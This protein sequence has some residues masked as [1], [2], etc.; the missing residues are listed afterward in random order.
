MIRICIE[1]IL[2]ITSL[3]H[4]EKI[5][6]RFDQDFSSKI[7]AGTL[8]V[9]I[10]D[11]SALVRQIMTDVLSQAGGINIRVAADPLI[12]MD[13]MKQS[14]PDVIVLDLVM[15]RMDGLTFLRKLMAENPIPVVVCSELVG[16]G[17]NEAIKALEMGAV[18]VIA[19]PKIGVSKFI[20]ES[21]MVLVDTVR[22]AASSRLKARSSFLNGSQ[23]K[24]AASVAP[25]KPPT[26]S[27]GFS[28]DKIIAL[29]ASTGGTDALKLILEAL[30]ADAPGIVIV[31]HM[32]EMFTAA[33][34]QRLNQSCAIE[35]KE[36]AN[37]DRVTAGRAL[38]A[39]G[40]YHMMLRRSGSSYTVEVTGGA[41]VSRHRPSVDVLF[42]SVAQ[43][44]G[45]KAIGAILTGMGS[46]GSMGLL[47]MKKAGAV[48]A[49]Q[50]EASCVVFGMPKEAISRG[51]ADHVISLGMMPG[52][53]M[54]K[55]R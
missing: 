1:Q 54:K 27:S 28:S 17:T 39:P 18:E 41:L 44:A 47:E 24:P 29:G 52:F 13:M 50:D 25:P 21:A 15:P 42:R 4:K 38:I 55:A 49:A 40:N 8:N 51:A 35:V 37:G 11:D 7:S 22:A 53:L 2:F 20:E 33:F 26:V 19:K 5:M 12:A 48:T 34:A 45:T 9:L 14:R 31:Q 6:G 30:P 3:P 23:Q 43:A 16:R 36:A 46:D 32:P 10:I